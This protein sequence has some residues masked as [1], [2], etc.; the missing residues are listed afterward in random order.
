MAIETM[1]AAATASVAAAANGNRLVLHDI[2]T[3]T[4]RLA[5]WLRRWVNERALPAEVSFALGVCLEQAVANI[6]MACE[7]ERDEVEIVVEIERTAVTVIARVEDNGRPLAYAAQS[8]VS[9]LDKAR[10][11]D[12]G[13]RLMRSFASGIEYEHHGDR[14]RLTLRFLQAEPSSMLTE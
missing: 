10:M 2:P 13:A 9:S 11:G 4:D 3:A 8:K 6:V 1:R 12:L 5:R 7:T 14:N